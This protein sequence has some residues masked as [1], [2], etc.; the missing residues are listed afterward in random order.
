RL[1]L[2]GRSPRHRGRGRRRAR[3]GAGG[4]V[5]GS[6][7]TAG[8]QAGTRAIRSVAVYTH[9]R[10]EVTRA[11]LEM[12]TASAERMGVE[13]RFDA[14]ETAKHGLDRLQLDNV[15][16]NAPDGEV[17]LCIVLGGD[18]TTLRMLRANAGTETPIFS[19]NC[20]R[21]GF[22]ATVDR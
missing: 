9:R 16:P 1:V 20:G 21:V 3:S 2:G 11:V 7:M 6:E 19:V 13:L 14:E 5:G 12:L 22:L 8:A 4:S 17:D 18:G 10:P 15:Q